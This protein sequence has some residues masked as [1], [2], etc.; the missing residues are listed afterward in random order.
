MYM[1]ILI[2]NP[3]TSKNVHENKSFWN[4]PHGVSNNLT[5]VLPYAL[6]TLKLDPPLTIWS[7]IYWASWIHWRRRSWE[8]GNYSSLLPHLFMLESASLCP[9]GA[10]ISTL[11]NISLSLYSF[12]WY[13]GLKW[14]MCRWRTRFLSFDKV[15]IEFVTI[16]SL[17]II[18]RNI[19]FSSITCV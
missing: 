1:Q 16:L 6:R 9:F 13:R 14:W 19:H 15:L 11:P 18:N 2:Q 4:F 5:L 12:H 8:Q 3:C 17:F 7:A 10:H